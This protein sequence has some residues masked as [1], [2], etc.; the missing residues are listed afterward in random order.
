[1]IVLSKAELVSVI[2]SEKCG[3]EEC[4]GAECIT[5]VGS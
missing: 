4:E 2:L 1:M 3:E 5:D